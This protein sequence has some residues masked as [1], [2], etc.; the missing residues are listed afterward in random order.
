MGAARKPCS[1]S[2][3]RRPGWKCGTCGQLITRVEDGWV[4]WLACEEDGVPYTK[5]IRL[6]HRAVV[7]GAESCHY[8]ARREFQRERGIVEGL[9]L[10]RFVGADGLMLLLSLISSGDM[11]AHEL[12]ELAKR[13]QIP[14]YELAREELQMATKSGFLFP[15]IGKGFYLQGEIQT[16]LHW[17]HKGSLNLREPWIDKRGRAF[18]R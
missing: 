6:V 10:E 3:C 12:I 17:G 13:V 15:A 11:P 9:S 2:R 1:D 14:G 16:V 4:E 8:D 18:R 5:G 7:T